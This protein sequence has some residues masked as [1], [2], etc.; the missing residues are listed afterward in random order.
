MRGIIFLLVVYFVK[1]L[2]KELSKPEVNQIDE[3]INAIPNREPIKYY[4]N[5]IELPYPFH[6]EYKMMMNTMVNSWMYKEEYQELVNENHNAPII[7]REILSP[8][9][10]KYTYTFNNVFLAESFLKDQCDYLNNLN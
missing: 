8:Y 9:I 2:I 6:I 5:G 10:Q 1:F 3:L 4:S 7:D